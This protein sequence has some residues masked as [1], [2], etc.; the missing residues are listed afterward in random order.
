MRKE[1]CEIIDGEGVFD[2]HGRGENILYYN[3]KPYAYEWSDYLGSIGKYLARSFLKIEVNKYLQH[4][5]YYAEKGMHDDVKLV[6]A[7]DPLLKLLS[8]GTYELMYP[9]KSAECGLDLINFEEQELVKLYPTAL[10]L[11]CLQP[12]RSL[13]ITRIEYFKEKIKDG[14]KPVI[15]V[16]GLYEASD[17]YI[18]DGHHKAYAYRS[19]N[20]EPNILFIKKIDGKIEVSEDRITEALNHI[21]TDVEIIKDI[22]P[23]TKQKRIRR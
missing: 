15:F 7:I 21:L 22:H 6:Y 8:N 9:F 16:F 10:T 3:Q 20:V 23:L 17:K 1:T 13:D 19:L 2:I 12:L 5:R 18:L 11:I 14:V 4:I